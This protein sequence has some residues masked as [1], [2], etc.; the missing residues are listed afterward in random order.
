MEIEAKVFDEASII[1][2]LEDKAIIV[3]GTAVETKKVGIEEAAIGY[4]SMWVTTAQ[5]M[6]ETEAIINAVMV[7]IKFSSAL[8]LAPND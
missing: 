6:A 1:K 2:V 4:T 5:V 3:M 8:A 7:T